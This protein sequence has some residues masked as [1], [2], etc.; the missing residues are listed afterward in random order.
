MLWRPAAATVVWLHD[1]AG[2][3]MKLVMPSNM[4]EERRA[5]MEA[6]GAEIMQVCAAHGT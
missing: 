6:Y 4:S 1:V 5:A 3:K 2:Y